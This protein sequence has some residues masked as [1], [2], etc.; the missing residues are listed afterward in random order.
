MRTPSAGTAQNTLAGWTVQ[1]IEAVMAHLRGRGVT[2]ENH[3]MG[4]LKTV[5]GLADVGMT[6]AAF[7]GTR[8]GNTYE[9][10]EVMGA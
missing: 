6:T 4:E 7:P 8:M 5:Y 3:D 10:S 1:D 2:F 9:P